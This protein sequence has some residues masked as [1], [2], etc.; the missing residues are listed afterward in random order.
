MGPDSALLE[1][2]D[3]LTLQG[4]VWSREAGQGPVV[5][6][7]SRSGRNQWVAYTFGKV[8]G[9]KPLFIRS[10]GLG[11]GKGVRHCSCRWGRSV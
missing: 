3:F 5:P 2:A 7:S 8:Q 1:E 6:E 10:E 11:L 4:T 9:P